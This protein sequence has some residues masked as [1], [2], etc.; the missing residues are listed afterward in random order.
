RR[1]KHKNPEER[2]SRFRDPMINIS[3]RPAEVE[4]RAIPGHWEG[5]LITGAHNKTAI[6]TLV[7]R[8][9]RYVMLVHLPGDHTAETVRDG[10][11]KT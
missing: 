2:T 10:L 5:D 4:D 7:E 8:T 9:T 3:E 1:K 11:I 6:A